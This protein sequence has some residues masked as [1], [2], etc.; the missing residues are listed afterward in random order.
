LLRSLVADCRQKSTRASSQA[1]LDIT[2]P[3]RLFG[4]QRQLSVWFAR[5]C[6]R[7]A[8]RR[9]IRSVDVQVASDNLEFDLANSQSVSNRE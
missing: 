9:S 5:S 7:F 2:I 3:R 4:A 1:S 6:G 8:C